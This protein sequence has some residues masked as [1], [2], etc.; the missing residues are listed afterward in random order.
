[1]LSER[2]KKSLSCTAI[3]LGLE[4]DFCNKRGHLLAVLFNISVLL[5]CLKGTSAT[6][7]HKTDLLVVE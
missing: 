3:E 4:N 1:M 7:F 5:D 2:A 6:I